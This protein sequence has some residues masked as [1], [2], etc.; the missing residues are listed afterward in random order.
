MMK[1]TVLCVIP[2]AK[3][4]KSYNP[5]AIDVTAFFILAI[6][7]LPKAE[8]PTAFWNGELKHEM[9]TNQNV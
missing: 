1:T 9:N 2:L 4:S 8:P 3:R 5:P 7:G 6:P